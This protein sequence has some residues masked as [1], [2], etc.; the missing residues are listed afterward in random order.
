[1]AER[2]RITTVESRGERLNIRVRPA[3]LAELEELARAEG[4]T[5]SSYASNALEEHV[6]R[7][8]RMAAKKS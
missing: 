2:R 1:M 4:R 7:I 8:K 3:L 6:R 5:M